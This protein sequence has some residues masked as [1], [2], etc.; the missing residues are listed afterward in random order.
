MQVVVLPDRRLPIAFGPPAVILIPNNW[1]D[2]GYRTSYDLW[3]RPEINAAPRDIGRVKIAQVGQQPGPSPLPAGT[4]ESLSLAGNGRWFS[5]GQD[6]TYYDNI[7]KL[8]R[9]FSATVYAVL[10]DLAFTSSHV[11]IP[12]WAGERLDTALLHEVTTVS[13]L[14]SVDERTV[15]GQFHR[16]TTG[17]PRLTAYQFDFTPG[18][19]T[20]PLEFRVRPHS[21]P[22]SNVHV[23]VGRNGVGKTRLL[24]SLAQA[25]VHPNQVGTVGSVAIVPSNIAADNH[26]FVNVVSVTF[27]AFDR[28]TDSADISA[29][30]AAGHVHIGLTRDE[31]SPSLDTETHLSLD[32]VHSLREVLASPQLVLWFSCLEMLSRDPHFAD[33]PIRD[34]AAELLSLDQDEMKREK[35]GDIR[36]AFDE[37]S[38]GHAIVL[39]TI[40]KLT[41]H[42]AERSLVLIDEP[43]SHLHP[44]L[45]ASFIQTLSYLLTN[46]NGIALIAT[47]SPVVLQEVP[48]SCVL[49]LSRNGEYSRARRPRIETYGENVGVL[50]HEIFGLEVMQSGF[51]SEIEKAVAEFDTYDEVLAHFD[52]QLG[53]EAKG[54]VR[55]LLADKEREDD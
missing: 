8:G 39:L 42:V 14:R 50:T 46:R 9:A 2:F 19:G 52:R 31:R 7:R 41:E 40:T 36:Q 21:N 11:N 49:K 24:R 44:P 35:E 4:F 30:A 18:P 26:G 43:E 54:L 37:L 15:L 48:R 55:I 27:S 5:L 20:D 38:S 23:L 53:D 51:Y 28:L 47:H 12:E 34:L 45:L 22:P 33:L 17:G 16:I 29:E 3:I 13:L 6:D 10:N 32:F 1:D 25:V